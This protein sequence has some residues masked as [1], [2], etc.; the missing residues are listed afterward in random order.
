MARHSVSGMP[1]RPFDPFDRLRAAIFDPEQG[2][3]CVVA[4]RQRRTDSCGCGSK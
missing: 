3:Q 4:T 1:D 2:S